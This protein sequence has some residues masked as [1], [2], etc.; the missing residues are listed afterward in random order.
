MSKQ[1]LL[2]RITKIE[3]F[4]DIT[5]QKIVD[6]IKWADLFIKAIKQFGKFEE[7]VVISDSMKGMTIVFTGFRDESLAS[8]IIERGGKIGSSVSRNTSVL[9]V[10]NLETKPSGNTK[11]AMDLNVVILQKA[12]FIKKYII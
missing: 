4:S 8:K 11:K 6:N 1:E 7:K 3:G 5:A 12:D 2:D 9:V 10:A